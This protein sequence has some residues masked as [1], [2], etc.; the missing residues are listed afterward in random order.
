MKKSSFVAI[1][2][3][4]SLFMNA[5]ILE[6]ENSRESV[7]ILGIDGVNRDYNEIDIIDSGI[8]DV[9]TFAPRS[10]RSAASV[11]SLPSVSKASKSERVLRLFVND[12]NLKVVLTKASQVKIKVVDEAG[13]VVLN[14]TISGPATNLS[15]IT[16]WADGN[17]V[18]YFYDSL[19]HQMSQS[20]F[21]KY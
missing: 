20:S 14:K 21:E 10:V 9:P 2:L 18:V 7:E 1:F 11:S 12:V 16:K 17:Y 3:L 8:I 4:V 19:G 13:K 5:G 15:N 6:K